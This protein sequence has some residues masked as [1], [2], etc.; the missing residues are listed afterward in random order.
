MAFVVAIGAAASGARAEPLPEACRPKPFRSE[1]DCSALARKERSLQGLDR[2]RYLPVLADGP[3]WLTIG[4]EYRAKIETLDPPDFGISPTNHSFT[5]REQRFLID[6]DLRTK[7]GWR[8]FVQLSAA[9]DTG[10]KPVERSFDRSDPD[11]QQAF[12]DVPLPLPH[13]PGSLRLGRQELD[14]GPNPLLSNREV[15]NLRLAFDMARLELRPRGGVVTIFWGRPVLNRPGAFDD[16]A[17]GTESFSGVVGSARPRLLGEAVE[18]QL[19]ALERRRDRAAYTDSVGKERRLA[20]GGVISGLRGPIDYAIKG[21]SESGRNGA[22]KVSAWSLTGAVGYRLK[23]VLWTPRFGLGYGWASGDDRRGDKKLNSFDPFY[24]NLGYFTSAPIDYP[25]NAGGL[26]P[27]L[28]L[29]PRKDVDI[30]LGTTVRL[31]ASPQDAVYSQTGAPAILTAGAGGDLLNILTFL[32]VTWR[33]A[34]RV[35]VAGAY[36]H[37]SAGPLVTRLGGRDLDY[38]LLQAGYK[39]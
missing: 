11:V 35:T 1:D 24:P 32:N 26:Q 20:L 39:F 8:A 21:V 38:G 22:S 17:P 3:V 36:V 13:L 18:V 37:G 30:A 28:D 31:R 4:G 23:S 10:R 2:L 7:A 19:F 25:I 33:A 27:V 14:L 9:L 34:P 12:V 5:A 29:S 6:A 15:G 16:R